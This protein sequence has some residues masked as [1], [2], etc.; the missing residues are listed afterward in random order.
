M[1]KD[2]SQETIPYSILELATVGKGVS[3]SDTFKNSLKLA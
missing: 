2:K 3:V 1:S